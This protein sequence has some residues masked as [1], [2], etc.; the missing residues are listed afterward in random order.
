VCP[1]VRDIFTAGG[2]SDYLIDGELHKNVPRIFLNL[3]DNLN[4][5]VE[6]LLETSAIE[7][8]EYWNK[9]TSDEKKILDWIDLV[10]EHSKTISTSRHLNLKKILSTLV[11]Q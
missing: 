8:T 7:L 1:N 2:K 6:S 4:L 10:H 3:F 11:L 9:Q 5:I